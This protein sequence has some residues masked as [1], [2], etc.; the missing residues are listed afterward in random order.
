MYFYF[1]C[2]LESKLFYTHES[3]VRKTI[4]YHSVRGEITG[5]QNQ[6][7]KLVKKM[8]GIKL[9]ITNTGTRTNDRA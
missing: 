3:H 8:E 2:P 1:N 9:D 7:K 4:N 6:W 5:S